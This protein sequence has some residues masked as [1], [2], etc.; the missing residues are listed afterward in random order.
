MKSNALKLAL[1][2][3]AALVAGG[4]VASATNYT[5]SGYNVTN[6]QTIQITGPNNIFGGMGQVV[7]HGSGGNTGLNLAVWCLDVFDWL[8]SSGTYN[9]GNLSSNP[10]GSQF[11][12]L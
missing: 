6:E 11:V 3:V 8:Q 1:P 9:S 5:Y 2:V 10:G 12:T 4:N 7:L